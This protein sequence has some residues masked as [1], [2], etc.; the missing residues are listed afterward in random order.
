[1]M[2]SAIFFCIIE[3]SSWLQEPDL[4]LHTPSRLLL[5]LPLPPHPL[6]CR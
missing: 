4:L 5:L 3:S 2:G 6:L 1:M